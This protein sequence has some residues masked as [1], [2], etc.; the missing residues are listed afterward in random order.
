VADKSELQHIPRA[1]DA[2]VLSEARSSLIARASDAGKTIMARKPDPAL[3]AKVKMN[4]RWG[5]IDKNGRFAVEP[6]CCDI[7]D[8]SCGMAAFSDVPVQRSKRLYQRA[9]DD[10]VGRQ[11]RPL[12][13]P[14]LWGYHPG[15]W[16]FADFKWRVAIL[17]R[18]KWARDFR[19]EI[20]GVSE[21]ERW[22]FLSKDGGFVIEPQFEA[23]GD[24]S[25]GLCVAKAGGKYGLI[26]RRGDFVVEPLF[27]Y[28]WDFS[29][30]F[31]CAE[32]DKKYCFIGK[33]GEIAIP[34]IFDSAEDF[35]S[36]AAH[37]VLN[38]RLCLIDTRGDVIFTC[39]EEKEGNCVFIR[40][41]VGDFAD[42]FALVSG[43][44]SARASECGHDVQ[45]CDGVCSNDPCTCPYSKRIC[46]QCTWPIGYYIDRAGKPLKMPVGTVGIED[47]NEGTALV[48]TQQGERMWI[49]RS[50]NFV[51]APNKEAT[52][53]RNADVAVKGGLVSIE[54]NGLY[55]F[56]DEMGRVVIEP[57]F[58]WVD[59]FSNGMARFNT[60]RFRDGKWGF[61]DRT[62][63]AVIP[64][65]FDE[66]QDFE[67]AT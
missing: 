25:G 28:L 26:N 37:V 20:A 22:G 11:D 8:F 23:V 46:R 36:G 16:G 54:A 1:V 5:L 10:L 14:S 41:E 4:G 9:L 2:L 15:H 44:Y 13:R 62:G 35:R 21:G 53:S 63:E 45:S 65:Q 19:E 27:S 18:F 32:I 12:E 66:A 43:R 7:R 38:G 6:F 58:A 49:D 61:I 29:E 51:D 39:A 30:G 40:E 57:K 59:Y 67:A 33:N 52:D 34:P 50:G 47:F 64:P 60:S 31:A 55:G 42:D 56:S 48:E 17:P 3:R 24:F